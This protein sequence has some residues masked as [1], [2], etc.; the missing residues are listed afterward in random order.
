MMDR[1]QYM[2]APTLP[3]LSI[4][5]A[6]TLK[7]VRKKFYYTYRESAGKRGG[8]KRGD[9]AEERRVSTVTLQLTLG[10]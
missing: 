8:G 7:L 1:E 10:G 3:N 2:F 9:W 5:K 6:T 4:P